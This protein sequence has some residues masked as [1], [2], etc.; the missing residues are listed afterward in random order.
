MLVFRIDQREHIFLHA[1]S[2]A[3]SF[4]IVSQCITVKR[5]LF[6]FLLIFIA[7]LFNLCSPY[8]SFLSLTDIE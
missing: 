4:F 8:C 3:L 5:I 6:V 7:R 2:Y 1:Y